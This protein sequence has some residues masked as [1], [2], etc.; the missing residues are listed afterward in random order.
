MDYIIESPLYTYLVRKTKKD[1]KVAVN[2]NWYR[3]AHHRESNEAK[4]AYKAF[5]KS[6]I[7][8]LPRMNQIA[9]EL[10][11]YAPNKRLFDVGNIGSITEKFFLDAMVELGKLEDDNYTFVPETS[12]KFAGIDKLN[13]RVEITIKEITK[14]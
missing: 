1:K 13:P 10:S 12:C 6:R 11:I 14:C 5:M 8:E 3:N 2:L 4:I 7:E 9:L